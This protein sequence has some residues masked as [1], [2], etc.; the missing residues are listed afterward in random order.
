MFSFQF[1]LSDAGLLPNWKDKQSPLVQARNFVCAEL[2][3]LFDLH[4][5]GY[6]RG[7][8]SA[9]KKLVCM[10]YLLCITFYVPIL[11]SIL[12]LGNKYITH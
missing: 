2:D 3:S 11:Y 6:T 9:D 5:L 4:C 12:H 10:Q 1:G 7:P 8:R